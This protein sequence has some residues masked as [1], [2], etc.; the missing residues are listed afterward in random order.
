MPSSYQPVPRVSGRPHY[1]P[2]LVDRSKA[3]FAGTLDL[4]GGAAAVAPLARM[5]AARFP[6]H[7]ERATEA[8]GVVG[9]DPL[10]LFTAHLCYDALLGSGGMGCST[11][12]LAGPAGPVLARNMDW[13]PEA[14]VAR[15][16]C[17]VDEEFGTNAGFLG[18]V[19]AV[20]GLSRRGFAVA[21]NAAFGGADMT[22][23]PMLLFLRHVLD[24]AADFREALAMA[25]A[26]RLMAAGIITLVGTADD[27]RAVVERTPT[28]AAVRMPKG[29]EPLAATNHHRALARPELCPRYDHLIAHAGRQPPLEVLTHPGVLQTITAQH[30]VF[31]PA[32]QAAEMYVPTRLLAAGVGTGYTRD[33]LRG[34][35]TG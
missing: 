27:E 10:D 18:L 29:D 4:M 32:T 24:T 14:A 1:P 35:F 16:S 20:T 9:V 21:L 11:L 8:A 23:Y 19:G 26:E 12:A 3:L 34:L 5:V 2:E 6:A 31:C 15:A 25:K 28:R 22:G 33:E 30:V 13:V 7:F 17:L